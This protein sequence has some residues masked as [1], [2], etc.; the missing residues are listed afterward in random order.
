MKCLVKRPVVASATVLAAAS[1][2]VGGCGSNGNSAFN[3]ATGAVLLKTPLSAGTNAPVTIAGNYVT[4]GAAV[5]LS[6]SEQEL[7]IAYKLGA[8]GKLPDTVG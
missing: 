8:T 5:P 2:A 3:A 6:Q 7:I 4:A 1:L